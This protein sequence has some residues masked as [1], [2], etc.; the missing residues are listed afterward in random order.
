MGTAVTALAVAAVLGVTACTRGDPRPA[1]TVT[2]VPTASAEACRRFAERL[3]ATMG[4]SV[5]R[6]RT[7]PEDPHVAA[8][9]DDPPIVVRCGAPRTTAYEPG[10]QLF[11]VNGVPWFAEERTGFVVWSL[12]RS[13][14]NVEVTIPEQYTGDRLAAL[15][16]A[17][18]AA[19]A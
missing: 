12:P 3:P 8:Y 18:R 4:E 1:V 10:D 16:D 19:G 2:A 9:G 15:T 14:V 13:L 6:R 11:T 17:V 7:V 5:L